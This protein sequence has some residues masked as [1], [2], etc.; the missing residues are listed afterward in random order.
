MLGI[1]YLTVQALLVA[2]ANSSHSSAGN[3][4]SCMVVIRV[5]ILRDSAIERGRVPS[6]HSTGSAP[7]LQLLPTWWQFGDV[8]DTRGGGRFGC[9][10]LYAVFLYSVDV[11]L[12]CGG[13][14]RYQ[15]WYY[16]MKSQYTLYWIVLHCIALCGL[17]HCIVLQ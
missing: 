13:S 5:G 1:I 16:G 15:Q 9:R 10:C 8:A 3:M 6:T 14:V 11:M 7:R 12:W 4:Y 17:V 2:I